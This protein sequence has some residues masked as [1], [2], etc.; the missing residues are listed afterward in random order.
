MGL[1]PSINTISAAENSPENN[2]EDFNDN[3]FEDFEKNEDG[4]EPRRQDFDQTIVDFDPSQVEAAA[5]DQKKTRDPG[6]S[7][8]SA[9]DGNG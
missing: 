7:L 4:P 2:L 5:L 8:Q 6:K 9:R 3:Q 1:H